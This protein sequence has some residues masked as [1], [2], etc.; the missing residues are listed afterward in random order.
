MQIIVGPSPLVVTAL[1]RTMISGDQGTHL[2]KLVTAADGKDVPGA[3]ASVT[4][5]GGTN[6]QVQYG[7]LTNPVTLTAGTAY[8]V[9]SQETLGGDQWCDINTIVTT[10]TGATHNAG[11]W[12][13]GPGQWYPYGTTNETYVPVDFRYLGSPATNPAPYITSATLGTSRNDFGGFVGMQIVVGA[14]PISVSAL[15]RSMISGNQGTHLLKLVSAADGTDVPGG[16]ASI[17]MSGGTNGQFQYAMLTNSVTLA[18]GTAYYVLS[19]E[20]L[21]GDQWCDINTTVTTANGA[22]HNAGVWG[23]GPGQWYPFG[24]ANQT[25]VPVD[26]KYIPQ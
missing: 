2:L 13:Y 10:T 19:Q 9:L 4:M 14:N 3:A 6:G 24:T 12:G 1:G 21:G 5:G 20:T 16:T 25:Y 8:Y 7:A 17:T 15:G 22:V 11:V 26:F 23:Y 18:A